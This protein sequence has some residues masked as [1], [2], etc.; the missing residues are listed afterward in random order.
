[1]KVRYAELSPNQLWRNSDQVFMVKRWTLSRCSGNIWPYCV[2]RVA[3]GASGRSAMSGLA[4]ELRHLRRGRGVMAADLC[5]RIGPKLRAL[6][7][8][9]AADSLEE[10][11]HRLILFLDG[12]AKV[13]PEDLSV[14][15]GAGLALDPD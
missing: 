3:V 1:M 10:S 13:L 6:A 7:G 11:R 2:G 4:D 8:I 5:E 12:L 14:A 9:E 15:F